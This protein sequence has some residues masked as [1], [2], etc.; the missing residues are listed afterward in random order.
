MYILANMGYF[1]VSDIIN[2][3]ISLVLF[4]TLEN[5]NCTLFSVFLSVFKLLH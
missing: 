4:F 2:D 1:V 5:N 3:K